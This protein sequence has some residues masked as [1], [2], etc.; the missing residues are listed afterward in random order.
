MVTPFSL[1]P[2][3]LSPGEI[4]SKKFEAPQNNP[5]EAQ[6]KELAA[7][8]E[9]LLVHEL[10]K[11]MRKTVNSEDDSFGLEMSTSM[12][13]EA[14]S[15]AI[16]GQLGIGDALIAQLQGD[17][18]RKHISTPSLSPILS[19]RSQ[20][21]SKSIPH[22]LPSNSIPESFKAT[23]ARPRSGVTWAQDAMVGQMPVEGIISSEFGH[24]I[25]PI[26][27]VRKFHAGV[28]IAADQGEEIHAVQSG[29]VRYAGKRGGY[30]LTVEL[31]H[32][33]GSITRYA[34]AS[35]IHVRK[36]DVV[37]AGEAIADVG[38]TGHSTGP[39]LHFEVRRKGKALDPLKYLESLRK[40]A[41]LA[42][43]RLDSTI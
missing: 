19:P 3:A 6:Q 4:N 22:T 10:I 9:S 16:A 7:Q 17:S 27:K 12:M 21:R 37:E 14:M 26:D 13:D 28:D 36:G 35:R 30:G 41:S 39:H 2:S 29:R 34:H 32:A 23:G 15:S 38:S 31:E 24:R 42:S 25:H 11:S 18:R 5:D 1:S 8:F 40:T 33:D 43:T 20:S